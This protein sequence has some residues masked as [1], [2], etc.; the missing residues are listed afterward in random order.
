MAPE[1]TASETATQ[2][3]VGYKPSDNVAQ[4]TPSLEELRQS[5][6]VPSLTSQELRT[7]TSGIVSIPGSSVTSPTA[8]GAEFGDVFAGFSYQSRTRFFGRRD[9]GGVVFGFGLGVEM[10]VE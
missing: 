1:L 4:T 9:D 8:F 3:I 10:M 7:L 5:Y 6:R 2:Y